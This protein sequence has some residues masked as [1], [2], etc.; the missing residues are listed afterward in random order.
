M[1][2][3]RSVSNERSTQVECSEGLG[4]IE[5]EG[6]EGIKETGEEIEEGERARENGFC[7]Y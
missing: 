7:Y 2:G 6:E 5:G 4:E 1:G 3:G